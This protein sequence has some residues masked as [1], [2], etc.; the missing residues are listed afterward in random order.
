MAQVIVSVPLPCCSTVV[1]QSLLHLHLHPRM[2]PPVVLQSLLWTAQLLSTC[3]PALESKGVCHLQ[4]VVL[5][6]LRHQKPIVL[7]SLLHV[8]IQPRSLP[9]RQNHPRQCPVVLQSLLRRQLYIRV[10][11]Q[12]LLPL[13]RAVRQVPHHLHQMPARMPSGRSLK[14]KETYHRSHLSFASTWR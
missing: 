1:L 11:L 3:A 14:S 10:V 13:R 4:Q 2:H 6:S 5:Q 8:R 12:S 9:H 7:Q